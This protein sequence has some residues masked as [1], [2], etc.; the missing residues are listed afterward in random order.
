MKLPDGS[1]V[2]LWFTD[3]GPEKCSVSVQV[4]GFSDRESA[5]EER[6]AWHRRLD[7]LVEWLDASG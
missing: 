3:K 2:A 7:R 6:D 5:D 1:T 4:G